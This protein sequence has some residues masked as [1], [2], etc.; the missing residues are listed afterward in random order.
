MKWPLSQQSG[1]ATG[2]WQMQVGSTPET[3]EGVKISIDMGKLT[4]VYI[5]YSIVYPIYPK[6]SCCVC[7]QR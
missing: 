6:L 3:I 1:I 5:L 2:T 7:A 4:L